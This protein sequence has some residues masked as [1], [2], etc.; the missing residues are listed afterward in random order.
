MIVL[1]DTYNMPQCGVNTLI[2]DTWDDFLRYI[3][4]YPEVYDRIITG[5]ANYHIQ[6][7]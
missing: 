1:N 4:N 2:F 5:Y 7:T 6:E 3:D